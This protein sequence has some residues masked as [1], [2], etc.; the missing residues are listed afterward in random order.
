MECRGAGP[1]ELVDDPGRCPFSAFFFLNLGLWPL[2]WC[3]WVALVQASEE[4]GLL[5]YRVQG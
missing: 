5:V 3:F 1:T 4:L 2:L